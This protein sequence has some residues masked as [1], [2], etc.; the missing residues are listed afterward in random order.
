MKTLATSKMVMFQANSLVKPFVGR[1]A[2][3]RVQSEDEKEK[4]EQN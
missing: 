3:E 2:N 4:H 1:D